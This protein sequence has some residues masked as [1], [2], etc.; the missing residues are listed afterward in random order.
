MSDFEKHGLDRRPF[1]KTNLVVVERVGKSN[2]ASGKRQRMTFRDGQRKIVGS[3]HGIGL[4]G[5]VRTPADDPDI[6]KAVIEQLQGA[7]RCCLLQRDFNIRVADHE[8]S[9]N[10]GQELGD[11]RRVGGQAN[12]TA[13]PRSESTHLRTN[14]INHLK[15]AAS[16]SQKRLAGGRQLNALAR[17]QQERCAVGGFQIEHALGDR[18]RG[19]VAPCGGA[20]NVEVLG[21]R[22]EEIEARVINPH[23]CAAFYPLLNMRI[24]PNLGPKTS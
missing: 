11:G 23:A 10:F 6:G 13:Q 8:F 9:Q 15:Q 24:L 7:P 3:E 4:R 20:G 1:F 19:D 17:E 14:A 16:V 18:R 5:I 2:G 21:N 22:D 12:M